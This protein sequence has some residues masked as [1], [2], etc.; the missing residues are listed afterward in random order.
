MKCQLDKVLR[1]ACPSERVARAHWL[2]VQAPG[3]DVGDQMGRAVSVSSATRGRVALSW[4]LSRQNIEHRI[5]S[6]N[7]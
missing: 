6:D 5:N 1:K 3:Q 4:L 2:G 7:F